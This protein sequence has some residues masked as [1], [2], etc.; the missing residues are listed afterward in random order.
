MIKVLVLNGPNLNLLGIREPRIYGNIDFQSLNNLILE[1]AREKNIEVEIKQSNF[2]G[3]LIDWIQEYREWADAIII[4]PGAL[5][6]YSYSLRD[7][8]L[9]FGKPVIEVHISNIYKREEF[10]RHSVIA[11]VSLGQI[12]GFGIY[13]YILALEAISLHFSA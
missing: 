10:R 12:S 3:Q 1:K 13:S 9:D 2:E 11:D 5:T 8:L 7:A 4:N 6:H